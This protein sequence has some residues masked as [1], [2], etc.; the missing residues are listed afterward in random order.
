M[1]AA[2]LTVSA[3]GM[4]TPS[5]S[6]AA[7]PSGEGLIA[8]DPLPG[9]TVEEGGPFTGA[10]DEGKM[11]VLGGLDPADVPDEAHNLSGQ[12]RTW[13]NDAG[14]HAVIL[15]LDCGDVPTASNVLAA[16]VHSTTKVSDSTFDPG[17]DGSAGFTS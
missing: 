17:F 12:A 14:D 15:V 10:F 13:V 6:F 4:M 7:T 5:R 1:T 16:G 11:M 2:L 9:Y 8:V 3:T